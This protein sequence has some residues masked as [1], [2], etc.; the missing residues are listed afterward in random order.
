M[1][2]FLLSIYLSKLII[3]NYIL[4]FITK[5]K[6]EQEFMSGQYRFHISPLHPKLTCRKLQGND[7]IVTFEKEQISCRCVLW[8]A[9]G[10]A[11]GSCHSSHER[12]P[13]GWHERPICRCSAGGFQFQK[14]SLSH[15]AG[16]PCSRSLGTEIPYFQLSETSLPK[17]KDTSR[18]NVWD[19]ILVAKLKWFLHWIKPYRFLC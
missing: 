10:R 2:F 12:P 5:C 11:R 19:Q 4:D 18:L 9:G 13:S 7:Q 3:V 1:S 14:A 15:L 8:V 17:T 16:D 6:K